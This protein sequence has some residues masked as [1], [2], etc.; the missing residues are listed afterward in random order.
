M[1][2]PRPRA[3]VFDLDGTL[4]DTLGDIAL[5]L[6]RALELHGR[7]APDRDAVAR[8]VGDGARVLVARA[9]SAA[10]DAALTEAVLASFLDA[11]AADPTPAT[12]L[13]PGA[14]ELL[15][16]LRVRSIPAVVCTNKPGPLARLIVERIF[17][18][19]IVATFGG[20]DTARLKPD[21]EPIVA[22]LTRV[23]VAQAAAW[24]VGDGP[25]DIAAARAA[26]VFAIGVRGGYGNAEGADLTIDALDE[27][28][29]SL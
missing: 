27:L 26:G 13:M 5:A 25:Q 21:P 6:G 16:A 9:L 2:I 28:I 29:A 10:P 3:V 22:S 17:G 1:L 14:A 20:G 12:R 7:P 15:A 23:G 24:M 4:L 19:Q 8:M 18:T 11:Y